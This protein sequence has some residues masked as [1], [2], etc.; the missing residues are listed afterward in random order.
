MKNI[1]FI[2][3]APASGKSVAKRYIGEFLEDDGF[4]VIHMSDKEELLRVVENEMNGKAS[5]PNGSVESEN[6]I[7]LDPSKPRESWGMVFKTA[8]SLNTAHEEMFATIRDLSREYDPGR[9]VLAEIAYGQDVE[10]PGGPLRQSAGEFVT[11]FMRLGIAN[12]MLI[13]DI[14]AGLEARRPRNLLRTVG[15]IPDGEFIK[16]FGDGGGFG[17]TETQF[18]DGRYC[19]IKNEGV[20]LAELT[21][22]ITGVYDMFIRPGIRGEGQRSSPEFF[23]PRT[24]R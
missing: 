15:P 3:G 23:N 18:L 19:G 22:E 14:Q 6:T 24:R 4:H 8:R 16:Y 13:L 12:K 20:S 21:R 7:L 11:Q 9:V 2:A 10:Y 5:N 1:V 17:K